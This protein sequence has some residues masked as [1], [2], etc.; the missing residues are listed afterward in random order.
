MWQSSIVL[1]REAMQIVV[2]SLR[3]TVRRSDSGVI[4]P[5]SYSR[6]EL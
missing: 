6:D 1:P 4:L 5:Y 2:R 3:L